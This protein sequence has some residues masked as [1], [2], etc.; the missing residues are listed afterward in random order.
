MIYANIDQLVDV[1][2]SLKELTLNPI[3]HIYAFLDHIHHSMQQNFVID[4]QKLQSE[5]KKEKL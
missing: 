3:D 5:N 2:L 1:Y 4:H